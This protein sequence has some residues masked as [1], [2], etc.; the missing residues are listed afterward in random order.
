[1]TRT[2][3]DSLG[4]NEDI[5]LDLSMLEAQGTILHDESKN[6]IIAT[7]HKSAGTIVWDALAS[8][9]Y[10]I[11]LN[12]QR[13]MGVYVA[14][15]YLDAPAVDTLNLDFTNGDYS[16]AIWFRWTFQTVSQIL[17]GKYV[18]N[19]CGWEVYLHKSLGNCSVTV[20][21]HHAGGA[22][23]RTA[24]YSYGWEDDGTERLFSYSR[25]GGN[26]Q[27]YLNGEPVT[28]VVSAGGL[29][30]P[31]S[32]A[33]RDLIIG[34]RY[35]LDTNFFYGHFHRPRAWSRALAPEEHRLL[36]RLGKP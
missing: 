28:T 32:S 33:A 5:E 16:L 29:I 36:Y 22:T 6:H 24:S 26:C 19:N 13:I 9:R 11:F 30:D 35:S 12:N 31:E 10:G 17:F 8:G 25:I 18:V 27:H 14:K 3:Y 7:Q 4:L 2:F 20:R 1:M 15:Q 23:L 21:H 34:V